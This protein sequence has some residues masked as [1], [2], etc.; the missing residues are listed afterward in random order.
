MC[1]YSFRLFISYLLCLLWIFSIPF[2]VYC[3]LCIYVL[4]IAIQMCIE[5][6]VY[7]YPDVFCLSQY[8]IA[9]Q[10]CFVYCD[11]LSRSSYVSSIVMRIQICYVCCDL[12]SRSS[13]VSSGALFYRFLDWSEFFVVFSID[14]NY[15]WYYRLICDSLR[16]LTGC[17]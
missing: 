3:N 5:R 4:Y 6:L 17:S 13:Y 7:R 14:L 8:F 16:R 15:L 10:T 11:I 1:L 9:F 2:R 12:L